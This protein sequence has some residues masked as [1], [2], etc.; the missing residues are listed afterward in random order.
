MRILM[1]AH[2]I[3]YPPHTG[4]KVRAYHVARHLA[5]HHEVTL[6]FLVDDRADL[7]GLYPL[8]QVVP[9]LEYARLWK[10]WSTLKGLVGLAGGSSLSVPYF[11][12]RRLRLR[13]SERIA[14][15]EYDLIYASST[16][17]AQYAE[18]LGIPV[19]MDFVDIDSDKWNQY[20]RHTAPPRSWIYRIEGRRLQGCEAAIARWA[21]LC[22]LATP[23][24]EALL[25]SFAPWATTAVV[26]N[27]I[28][29]SYHTPIGNEP[30]HPAI[31]F[32][33]AMDY[34]PN[35][36]AV[37]YFCD[38]IL[39]LV[40]RELRDTV[41]L[42]VGKNP[43]PEVRRLA[44]MPGVVVSGS[45]PD[46]RPYYARAGVGVAPLR[47]GRGVQNKVLQSMAMGVPV[48]T[49][50]VG[51]RGIGAQPGRHFEVADEPDAFAAH[52]VRLLREPAERK[53]LG[54]NG[55][56]FVEANHAWECSLAK[57]DGLL[58]E[59]AKRPGGSARG[60]HRV[61]AVPGRVQR[62]RT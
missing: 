48:V 14:A 38:E 11:G 51:A 61:S 17:T 30:A 2:R 59:A 12:S 36:D 7:A 34:L 22:V 13:L 45:V 37:Q 62:S 6:A 26:A 52:V 49:T 19:V 56:G 3:P 35:V 10:P 47:L 21:A 55:R 24:E 16:P 33:G 25:K 15:Q 29:L 60:L 58:A 54:R 44:G 23:A 9:R 20:A 53:I 32:T 50:T 1:L 27:G 41:F 4:D 42:I 40:R 5:R 46:V 57:M 31:L 18:G 28:D 43:S 8:S 39:P